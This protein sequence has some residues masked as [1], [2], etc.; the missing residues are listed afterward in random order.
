MVV[1]GSGTRVLVTGASGLIGRAVTEN[2]LHQNGYSI[3]AHVRDSA[4]ARACAGQAIDLTRVQ[5]IEG[6]FTRIGEKVLADLTKN[7]DVIIHTAGLVHKPNA[8]YEEY[9]VVNARATQQLVEAA[10]ANKAKTF[11][12]LSTSAVYGSGPFTDIVETGPLKGKTPYAV[13]KMRSE[14]LLQSFKGIP[15]IIVLRPCLVFGEGDRG[16]LLGLIKQI[17]ANRYKHIGSGA[18]SKSVIYSKDVAKAIVLCLQKLPDGYHVFNLA[19]PE[20]VSVRVLAEK[21]ASC[22]NMNPK[23]SSVPEAVLRIAAKAA[24]LFMQ[25]KSPVTIEQIEK[26]TTTTTCSIAKLVSQTGFAPD[27]SLEKALKAEITWAKASNLI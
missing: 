24:E 27:N 1:K 17:K 7:C 23:I 3:K 11:V 21:I 15:R 12:F 6:D 26:L 4:H 22:L 13:S 5:L 25:E 19:N 8:P 16:N 14:S 10:A 2:L 20:S 9:E 18:T